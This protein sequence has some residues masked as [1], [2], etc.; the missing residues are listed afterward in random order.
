MCRYAA[1]STETAAIGRA[2]I[3]DPATSSAENMP[4][5]DTVAQ[6]GALRRSKTSINAPRT[7]PAINPPKCPP[8]DMRGIS[9]VKTM[10]SINSGAS[11]ERQMLPP[12]DRCTST[13]APIKPNTAPEA[14][15]VGEFGADSNSAPNAPPS[16]DT[17]NSD[18][19]RARPKPASS[20]CPRIQ[21]MYMLKA[22]WKIPSCRK[23]D[24]TSR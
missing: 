1:N 10:L 19:N 12:T 22:R 3:S 9:S 20:I 14:P 2:A 13:V 6:T 21:R 15:T 11:G 24:V 16:I 4:P 17:M 8:I 23:A 18:K 5:K 7:A